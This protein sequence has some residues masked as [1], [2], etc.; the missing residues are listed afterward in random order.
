MEKIQ[1]ITTAQE[2]AI[3]RMC[4]DIDSILTGV[5]DEEF[6]EE[7]KWIE[8]MSGLKTRI[9]DS[10][11]EF[12]SHNIVSWGSELLSLVRW[13]RG[14]VIAGVTLT[15]E[16]HTLITQALLRSRVGPV[17]YD[18]ETLTISR[19]PIA[20][21]HDARGRLHCENGAALRYRDGWGLFQLHGVSVPEWAV[22]DPRETITAERV[23]NLENVESR[24]VILD[25]VGW[26]ILELTVIDACPD[27]G[28]E[29]YELELCE[30]H[31]E[32]WTRDRLLRC[33][34]ATI[35]RDGTRRKFVLT[36]PTTC[37]KA[38]EAAAWCANLTTQ[39][40][41]EIEVAS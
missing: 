22:S 4:D 23:L 6:Q 17:E 16:V 5:T 14:A 34:N 30:V 11:K 21:Y 10:P 31:A 9:V 33:T 25:L 26:D 28:N 13:Y 18:D 41:L 35:D 15:D 39:E 12:K 19:P 20:R 37:T 29:G 7:V 3:A 1:T 8:A 24:R 38:I 32:V 40:Y 2:D 36:V 27:P